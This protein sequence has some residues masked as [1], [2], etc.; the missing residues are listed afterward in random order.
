MK[1]IVFQGKR[2]KTLKKFENS[3]FEKII[4]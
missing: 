1:G 3:F 4:E 2:K